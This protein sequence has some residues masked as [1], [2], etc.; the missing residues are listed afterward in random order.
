MK[1]LERKKKIFDPD[2]SVFY[3]FFSYEKIFV[4]CF[5]CGKLG[6]TDS[7]CDLFLIHKRSE[8]KPLWDERLRASVTFP[9]V[10]FL[11]AF[12]CGGYKFPWNLCCGNWFY[13][14]SVISKFF[15]AFARDKV[16]GVGI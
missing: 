8:L 6:H 16:S 14:F 3:A 4:Y 15:F 1:L 9:K 5:L 7:Y 10:K 11:V 13:S 12:R 2:G